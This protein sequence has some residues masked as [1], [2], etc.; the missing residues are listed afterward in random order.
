M[1]P[2]VIGFLIT[3]KC[4]AA[5]QHC[6]FESGPKRTESMTRDQA[7]SYVRQVAE[8]GY[9]RGI[10]I[11]G[12]EAFL[13]YALLRDVIREAGTHG[14]SA[15]VVSNCFWAL[16][17]ERARAKLTPLVGHGL[18][19]LSVSY[20]AVHEEFVRRERVRFAVAAALEL[21]LKV[22]VST[23]HANGN[24]DDHIS[25]IQDEL[26]LPENDR[27]FIMPGY[28]VPSGRASQQFSVESLALV[29]GEQPEGARLRRPCAHVIREPIITPNGDLAACCSPSTAI[30]TGFNGNYVI[31]SL[32]DRHLA[33]LL[34][35]LETNTVFNSIMIDGPWRL[36][37]MV[38]QRDPSAI[39]RKK[40]VNICD[41]CQQVMSNPRAREILAEEFSDKEVIRLWVKKLSLEAQA[42]GDVDDYVMKRLG[43]VQMRPH[44]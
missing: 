4:N 1:K 43:L 27:L 5:C 16:S 37:E 30:R 31:G 20:D 35:D 10:S 26:E 3:L 18:T 8:V 12:G 25:R 7:L 44:K 6:C 2:R 15:R 38:E 24:M 32:Q 23:V 28:I 42:D 22:V 41:L 9:L 17:P 39:K 14:L 40:F 11:T 33:D 13:D 34:D 21:G 36:F 29:D 19:E